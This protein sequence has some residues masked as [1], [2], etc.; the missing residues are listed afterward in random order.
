MSSKTYVF[1]EQKHLYHNTRYFIKSKLK[2]KCVGG[3]SMTKEKSELV[4]IDSDEI[5][6]AFK[7]KVGRKWEEL[8]NQ[9]PEGQSLIVPEE[10]GTGA[11]IRKAVKDINE[12][13]EKETYKTIQ[14]TVD[15]KLIIYVKRL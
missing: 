4:F 1:V 7:G 15:E 12:R 5:P 2:I 14:R 10:Y 13:L 3:E 9:I 11:T 8:F 6:R